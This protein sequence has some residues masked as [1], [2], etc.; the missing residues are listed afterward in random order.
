M[1]TNDK[2]NLSVAKSIASLTAAGYNVAVPIGEGLSYDLVIERDNNFYSC[3]VKTAQWDNGCV[4]C[5]TKSNNGRWFNKGDKRTYEGKADYFCIYSPHTDNCY[6]VEVTDRTA[7]YL[8]VD[9][10][11]IYNATFNWARDYEI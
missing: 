1:N 4:V 6:L 7:I 3:Q 11:K 5:H 10:P 9:E 2:G 8:R